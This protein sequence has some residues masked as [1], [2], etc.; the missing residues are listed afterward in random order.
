MTPL[1][2]LTTGTQVVPESCPDIEK[3]RPRGPRRLVNFQLA[4]EA[5]SR[6]QQGV[7]TPL[8]KAVQRCHPVILPSGH[9]VILSSLRQ[10]RHIACQHHQADQ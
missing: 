1:Y 2:C 10:R 9:P 6:C 3:L 8:G 5:A 4:A 7:L